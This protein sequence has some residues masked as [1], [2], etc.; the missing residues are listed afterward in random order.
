MSVKELEALLKN[1]LKSYEDDYNRINAE[2][3]KIAFNVTFT[4]H[5]F[6]AADVPD[7]DASDKKFDHATELDGQELYYFRISK[8][9]LDDNEKRVIF[10]TYR[11]SKSMKPA[12]AE[13][14]MYLE[15]IR[16]L[17]IGG[18][19]YSEAIYRLNKVEE[20]QK[21]NQKEPGAHPKGAAV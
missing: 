2:L 6:V 7:Y 1:T 8:T 19:E 20:G 16:N 12:V 17:M 21:E 11:P 14:A 4:R 13:R 5:K 10:T 15:A 3:P 18:L 9:I